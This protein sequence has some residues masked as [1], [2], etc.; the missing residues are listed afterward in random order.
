MELHLCCP[1]RGSISSPSPN[2]GVSPKVSSPPFLCAMQGQAVTPGMFQRGEELEFQLRES[3]NSPSPV[4]KELRN[5]SSQ[6]GASGVEIPG[7]GVPGLDPS[8]PR[9]AVPL[10]PPSPGDCPQDLGIPQAPWEQLWV[11]T[12]V[13]PPSQSYKKSLSDPKPLEPGCSFPALPCQAPGTGAGSC[14]DPAQPHPHPPDVTSTLTSLL[15]DPLEHLPAA[16]R[17]AE[18]DPRALLAP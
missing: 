5:S 13:S 1:E 6:K 10:Q 15:A 17:P 8:H 4:G 16:A 12:W 2:P 3:R 14:R 7:F 18:A 9:M 11:F